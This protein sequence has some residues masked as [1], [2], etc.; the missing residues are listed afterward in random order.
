MPGPFQSYA[1]PGVYTRTLID[2]ALAGLAGGLRIPVLLG[3]S[4]ESIR[5]DD[6]EM[7]RGSSA[8]TDTLIV[9]EDLSSQIFQDEQLTNEFYLA[10]V[11]VVTGDGTGRVTNRPSASR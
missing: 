6:Y 7:F 11:P 5:V 2:P 10:H 3:C 8:N 9:E 4:S 1:P